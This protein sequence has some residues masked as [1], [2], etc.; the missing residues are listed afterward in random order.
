MMHVIMDTGPWV[1][2]IDRSEAKHG[3]C[4]EWFR[5]FE[6]GI[7]TS[8]AVLTRSSFSAQFFLLSPISGDRLCFK[9]SHHDRA[10]EPRKSRDSERIDAEACECPDGLCGCLFGLSCGRPFDCS[11][12][13]LR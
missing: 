5:R 1:A 4:A 3:E 2:L 9:W 6:G 7:Y 13:D 8:E 12:A 11:C 10:S